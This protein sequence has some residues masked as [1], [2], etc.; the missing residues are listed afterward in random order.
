MVNHRTDCPFRPGDRVTLKPMIGGL[1]KHN[2][3]VK[4]I[5]YI[6][7]LHPHWRLSAE[8]EGLYTAEG[9][10]YCFEAEK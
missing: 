2:L 6:D 9:A 8:G 7:N 4:T 10:I 5:Y 1:A 3:T